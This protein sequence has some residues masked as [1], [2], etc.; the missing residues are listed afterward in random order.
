MP[1]FSSSLQLLTATI[2]NGATISDAQDVGQARLARLSMPAAFTGTAISF[3]V[4]AADGITYNALTNDAGVAYSITVAASKEVIVDMS[5]MFGVQ[6]F[7][8]VSNAAEGAAR[9]IG[10]VLAP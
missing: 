8:L 3:L 6:Q 2:A 9:S 7:K 4:L 5:K 1:G 10:C